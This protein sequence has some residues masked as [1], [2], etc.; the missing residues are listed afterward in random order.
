MA[1]NNLGVV[2][3]QFSKACA[4]LTKRL[5]K[6]EDTEIEEAVIKVLNE[7]LLQWDLINLAQTETLSTCLLLLENSYGDCPKIRKIL[8][9]LADKHKIQL[10]NRT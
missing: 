2:L 9:G 5:R 8:I 1:K 7:I 10:S 6:D 3:T 4:T